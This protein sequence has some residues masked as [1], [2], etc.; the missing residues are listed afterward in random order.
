MFNIIKFIKERAQL[1]ILK[2]PKEYPLGQFLNLKEIKTVGFI[3]NISGVNYIDDIK[4][5]TNI[6][7]KVGVLYSGLAIE[8]RKGILPS[9]IGRA[10][11]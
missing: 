7:N 11:V 8:T 9:E 1:K 10:H 2:S 4:I 6:L 3:Y 5:I